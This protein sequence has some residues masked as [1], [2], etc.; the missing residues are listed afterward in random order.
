MSDPMSKPCPRCNGTGKTITG[1]EA[2]NWREHAG[3][4]LSQVSKNMG[5]SLTYL[6]DLEHD[7][8]PWNHKLIAKLHK[9]AK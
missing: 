9:A 5:I 4:T 2:R 7:R 3:L 8:R 1:L 6:S